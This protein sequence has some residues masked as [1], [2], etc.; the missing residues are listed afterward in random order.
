MANMSSKSLVDTPAFRAKYMTPK[1]ASE[2]WNCGIQSVYQAI[3]KK[4][5]EP[6]CYYKIDGRHYIKRS[7]K[8]PFVEYQ[9]RSPEHLCFMSA[10]IPVDHYKQIETLI[11]NGKFKSITHFVCTA[12]KNELERE[13]NYA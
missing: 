9:K 13:E 3:R 4:Q 1:E 8:K 10:R 7:A 2:K 6:G 12:I 5:F 11:Q